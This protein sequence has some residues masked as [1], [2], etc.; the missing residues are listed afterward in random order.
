[1]FNCPYDRKSTSNASVAAPLRGREGLTHPQNIS[2]A[3]AMAFQVHYNANSG[4]WGGPRDNFAHRVNDIRYHINC[5][6]SADSSQIQTSP[7][8]G[9]SHNILVISHIMVNHTSTPLN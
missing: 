1:M 2:W 4:G 3:I 8:T 5:A 6:I 9:K 7:S